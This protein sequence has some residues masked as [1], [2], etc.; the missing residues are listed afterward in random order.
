MDGSKISVA[1]DLEADNLEVRFEGRQPVE[2]LPT[3]KIKAE[4][5]NLPVTQSVQVE[6]MPQA[7]EVQ[8][9]HIVQETAPNLRYVA[10]ETMTDTGT[11]SA[12]SKRKELILK[13]ADGNTGTIWLGGYEN[14]G[15]GLRPAEAFILS[16]G[17][18]VDVYLP[19][20]CELYVSE[21]TA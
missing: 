20:N 5:T 7:V 8:K 11:I 13:A 21:V 2:L 18:K 4:V 1:A 6:N 19:A 16:N 10:H 3:Q 14:R 15:Y 12:N 9:V 17:A